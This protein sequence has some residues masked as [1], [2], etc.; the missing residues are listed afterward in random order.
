MANRKRKGSKCDLRLTFNQQHNYYL[1]ERA[2]LILKRRGAWISLLDKKR[3][4]RMLAG[5]KYLL[6]LTFQAM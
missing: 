4:V 1:A 5:V 6:R 3:L 2:L